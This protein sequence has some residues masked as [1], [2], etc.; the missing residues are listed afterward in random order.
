KVVNQESEWEGVW[1]SGKIAILDA[2][3][4][5]RHDEGK[6]GCLPHS[7]AVTSD[8]IAARAAQVFRASELVLLKSSDGELN[9]GWQ[10]MEEQGIVDTTFKSLIS[11]EISIR[12]V[13]FRRWAKDHV[14]L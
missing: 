4:F 8:S 12:L 14:G 9:D 13:N 7:W 5:G 11:P 2:W 3:E 6:P 1:K 10:K